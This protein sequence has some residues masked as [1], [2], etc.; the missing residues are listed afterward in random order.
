M[1]I[2]KEERGWRYR[3]QLLGESYN[4]G[5]YKTRREAESAGAERRIA[6]KKSLKKV[7]VT[8]FSDIANKYLDYSKRKHAVQT[9]DYKALVYSSFIKH[10]GDMP[11]EAITP[12]HIH[13]YL[14]TRPSNHNY[15]A[16]R[17]DLSALWAFAIKQ[18]GMTIANPCHAIDKMPWT[19][20]NKFI[21]SEDIILKLILAADPKSDEQDLLL[22]V[23]HTLGRIDE[24]LRMKWEDVNFEKRTVTLWTRKCK[25]GAYEADALPMGNDL[26]EILMKR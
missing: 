16:H 3:F 14:N 8:A 25:D 26:Y 18:L 19:P 13:D 5:S 11:F 4:G 20:K 22:V 23:I 6:V 9:F 1:A 17:K 12:R 24:V 10:H 2:W 7:T 15:N 21:P